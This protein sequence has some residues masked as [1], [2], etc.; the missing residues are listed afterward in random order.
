MRIRRPS[1]AM[2]V[3]IIALVMATAGTSITLAWDA[4]TDDIGVTGYKVFKD[5]AFVADVTTGTS[6]QVTGLACDTSYLLQ[7][8]AFDAAA[9]VGER[10][11]LTARTSPCAPTGDTTAPSA[12][13][14]LRSTGSTQTTA[15][16]AW[17][18]AHDDV[19]VAGYRVFLDGVQVGDPGNVLTFT[20][21]GLSCGSAHTARVVAYDAAGNASQPS[22][23]FGFTTA[24]CPSATT[25]VTPAADA[26]VDANSPTRNFG[27]ATVL[28]VH[29][30]P[31]RRAY[32]RFVVPAGTPKSAVL[33]FWS[34]T[35]SSSGV[36]VHVATGTNAT[37]WG[38]SAITYQNAPPFGATAIGTKSSITIGSNDVPLQVANLTPGAAVT[39][40]ITRTAT[41]RTDIQSKENTNK[42]ALVI[43]T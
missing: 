20:Y 28:F 6:F 14:N 11:S 5:D 13:A 26:Y 38:E 41:T 34:N 10:A 16:V 1:P 15:T 18:A 29:G 23:D 17:D 7:V 39:L 42:P 24:A 22:A 27:A 25:T 33:R 2:V 4:A 31:V 12:P 40:V 30:S 21:N 43:T 9:K 3:S 8:S 37:T 35:S 32:M 19:G 36:S